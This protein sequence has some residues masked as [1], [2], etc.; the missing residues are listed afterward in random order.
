MT[1]SALFE[2]A[3]QHEEYRSEF[4]RNIDL[5][6]AVPYIHKV[7]YSSVQ[8]DIRHMTTLPSRL[9]SWFYRPST[10]STVI[11]YPR[12]FEHG[13]IET[14]DDFLSVLIDHEGAH[15]EDIYRN[16]TSIPLRTHPLF[17]SG[18]HQRRITFASEL[19][20]YDNQMAMYHSGHRSISPLLRAEIERR[21]A[22][23][24]EEQRLLEPE[25]Y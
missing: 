11:I 4:V 24:K 5:E 18:T 23:A 25:E 10:R 16:P 14:F 8:S 21:I 20:A 15:A 3:Q 17:S 12:S 2:E 22:K 1:T 7:V 9:A 6:Y 19:R 13:S